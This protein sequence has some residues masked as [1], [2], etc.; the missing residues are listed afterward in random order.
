[1]AEP[2]QFLAG[3]GSVGALMREK[4]WS[5]SPLGPPD[6]WPQSLRTVVGLLLQSRF[7]MFVAWGKDLGFLY[8]D[9]YAE[10]L[11][12]KHPAALGSR[13]HENLLQRVT[14]FAG[15]LPKNDPARDHQRRFGRKKPLH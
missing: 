1:M 11:G 9:P 13:F 5:F 2:A 15:E 3:G 8:N 14:D 10:I 12:A 7:P 4:D 6:S